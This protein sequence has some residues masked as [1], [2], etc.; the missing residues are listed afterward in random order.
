VNF[1]KHALVTISR[2]HQSRNVSWISW[3]SKLNV[4]WLNDGILHSITTDQWLAWTHVWIQLFETISFSETMLRKPH[5]WISI[6]I[7]DPVLSMTDMTILVITWSKLTVRHMASDV[8]S[9]SAQASQ[10]WWVSLWW[11]N[12]VDIESMRPA[13][14]NYLDH[15][16]TRTEYLHQKGYNMKSPHSCQK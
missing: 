1:Q 16:C 5:K 15:F 6:V 7:S 12:T 9:R 2:S 10:D 3:Q 11:P 14:T 4:L 13:A 8:R